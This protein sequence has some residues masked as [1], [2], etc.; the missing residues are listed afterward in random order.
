VTEV[1]T[2]AAPHVETAT[3]DRHSMPARLALGAV[4][5][6]QTLRAGR[7][8][9]CRFVPSCS[10]YAREALEEH[11]AVRGGW[12]AARRLARC[13]PLGGH[14]YDPVPARE[15]AGARPESRL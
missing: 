2:G 11:G 5:A 14:G 9:P 12:Y 6:Y 15:R 7:P 8:S 4:H 1:P 3:L 13:H 10:E